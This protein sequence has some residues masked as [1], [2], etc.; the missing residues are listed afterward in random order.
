MSSSGKMFL[1]SAAAWDDR[2]Q[3]AILQRVALGTALEHAFPFK[4]KY[5]NSTSN[6]DPV[7]RY[8]HYEQAYLAGDLDPAFEVLTAFEA[9]YVTD[10]D[11]VDEDLVWM[12]ETMA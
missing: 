4:H 10:T 7:A 5:V 12:R 11:A 6:V 8:L 1:S 2:S 3:E 9:R